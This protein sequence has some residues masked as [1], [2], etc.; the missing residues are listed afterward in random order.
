MVPSQVENIELWS[1]PFGPARS[2]SRGPHSVGD[3]WIGKN[4]QGDTY[5]L[6]V[7][8][9]E[10]YH[11]FVNN[12]ELWSEKMA[13]EERG[14]VFVWYWGTKTINDLDGNSYNVVDV[15][16]KTGT[17]VQTDLYPGAK[18]RFRIEIKG[19]ERDWDWGTL[20]SNGLQIGA[21]IVCVASGPPGWVTG[22]GYA[23]TIVGTADALGKTLGEVG[24]MGMDSG[25][26]ASGGKATLFGV[27]IIHKENGDFKK[28][29]WADGDNGLGGPNN[30]DMSRTE[31]GLGLP[32]DANV[33]PDEDSC[34]ALQTWTIKHTGTVAA[35]ICPKWNKSQR[36]ATA[37]LGFSLGDTAIEPDAESLKVKSDTNTYCPSGQWVGE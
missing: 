33:E 18:G 19:A 32:F 6:D 34:Q 23:A 5:N 28:Y 10:Q 7:H 8:C 3:K 36:M 15:C 11:P 12:G 4:A 9:R 27:L 24:N 30:S 22:L 31:Q 14:A 26:H 17:N 13:S 2:R 29:T 16:K 37:N 21:G 25:G 20:L 35:W 1:I